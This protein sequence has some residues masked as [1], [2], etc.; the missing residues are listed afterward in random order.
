MKISRRTLG[1]LLGV[2]AAAAVASPAVVAEGLLPMRHEGHERSFPQGFL[3]GSA[4]ASYQVEGAVKE[5]GRGVSIWDTFSHTP[6]KTHNG[7]TG[8]IADDFY[9]RYP[10]DI[11]MMK[12]LGL[13]TCRFS[14]AWPRIFPNGTGQPNQKG[15]DFYRRLSDKLRA[16][17]IEPYCT[18]YHWDLPQV[19]QDKGGWQNRDTAKAFADYA[20]YTA[21]KLS[22]TISHWMTVNEMS[23]FIGVGYRDGRHAP[24]LKLGP[25]DLA[26]AQH[27]AVLGHGLAVRAI[28][29]AAKNAIVGL[30][31][32]VSANVPVIETPEH[33]EAAKKAFREGNAP[34]MTV[35]QEGRYTERYLRKLGAN[36]PTFTAEDLAIISSPLDFVGVNVYTAG[37]VRADNSEDGYA[38]T[39]WPNGFPAMQSPWLRVVPES[40]YWVPKLMHEV[41]NV[42]TLYI[43]ENGASAADVMQADGQVYDIDRVMYLR[44]YWT[45]LQRATAE[46]VPVKGYFLWSLLDNYEWADGYEKRFGI[47][48][49]DFKTQTRTPKLSAKLY[50]ELI[51]RNALV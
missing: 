16:A 13:K 43:T 2:S 49:V 15:I 34:Y 14:I 50:S 7:D 3:W 17:G 33:I 31:E 41:W 12:E 42:K 5:D 6:G 39:S 18:L 30:A 38:H 23:T 46:G 1:R 10:Q 8:D 11:E 48:Y 35:I 36:A 21:G 25:K 26:Q 20:G 40:L 37:Y 32:N 51:R 29:A 19:L 27:H 24:G 45:Q 9:H 28:R 4:T 22:D 44:N 47:V